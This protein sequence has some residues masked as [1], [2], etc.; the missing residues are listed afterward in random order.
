MFADHSGMSASG[1]V[2][3]G[4]GDVHHVWLQLA[5][6]LSA[7]RELQQQ[8]RWLRERVALLLGGVQLLHPERLGPAQPLLEHCG[9]LRLLHQSL[10]R[11]PQYLHP[12]SLQ[13]LTALLDRWVAA[14]AD[15]S[16]SGGL[17]GHRLSSAPSAPARGP[18]CTGRGISSSPPA[19][20]RPNSSSSSR[21]THTRPGS[22]RGARTCESLGPRGAPSTRTHLGLCLL[23]YRAAAR[24]A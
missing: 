9:H 20:G 5:Q 18:A 3:L 10:T 4:S 21:G 7:Y 6:Q 19:L 13:G 23:R 1:H 2:L 22:A 15:A 17:R 24:A 14:D 8:S 16:P 12:R 11:Q